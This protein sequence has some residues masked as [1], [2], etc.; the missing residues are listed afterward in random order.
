MTFHVTRQEFIV[1]LLFL[2]LRGFIKVT[3]SLVTAFISPVQH[4]C[5]FI[6][7]L[8][9]RSCQLILTALI[10]RRLQTR[11]IFSLSVHVHVYSHLFERADLRAACEVHCPEPK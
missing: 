6:R 4:K 10:C 7:A 5:S 1:F 3:L 2:R 11:F 8:E 9:A